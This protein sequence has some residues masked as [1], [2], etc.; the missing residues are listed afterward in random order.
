MSVVISVD[1]FQLMQGTPM[2]TERL[3]SSGIK[4]IS[5]LCP[6]CYSRIYTGR[7]GRSTI[8]V[9]AGTLDDTSQ[10]R[11]VAQFW[12]ASAQPWALIKNRILSYVEQPTDYEPL[13]AAWKAALSGDWGWFARKS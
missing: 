3:L 6:S 13:F 9:R 4:N 8:N 11:P 2:R 1:G 5:Y 12:T 7:E 10:I